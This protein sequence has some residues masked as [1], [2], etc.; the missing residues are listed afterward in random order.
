VNKA[1]FDS[2]IYINYIDLIFLLKKMK[3]EEK[4]AEVSE[5]ATNPNSEAAANPNSEAAANPNPE[6]ATKDA[7][8]PETTISKNGDVCNL[9]K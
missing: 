7:N 1:H 5:A 6:A 2:N 8:Q 4:L 9:T 3:Q